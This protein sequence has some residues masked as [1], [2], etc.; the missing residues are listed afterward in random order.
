MALVP[1]PGP[2]H[3][4]AYGIA[5]EEPENDLEPAAEGQMSFLEPLAEIRPRIMPSSIP[6]ALGD[7]APCAFIQPIFEFILTP[8]LFFNDTAT[9]E[10]YTQPGE[11]FSLY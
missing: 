11:A 6:V 5:P 7:V 9:T 3:Q 10:I 8:V 2:Q 1:F 4:G